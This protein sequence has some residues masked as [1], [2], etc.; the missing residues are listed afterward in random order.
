VLYSKRKHFSTL[1]D[2]PPDHFLKGNVKFAAINNVLEKMTENC[3]KFGTNGIMRFRYP[4]ENP[5]IF[6]YKP[7]IVAEI[8]ENHA[9]KLNDR[10]MLTI[11]L[12][13][14]T[15]FG[16]DIF[17]ANG[18]YW[19]EARKTFVQ[20]VM[21]SVVRS[22]PIIEK[23]LQ[24]AVHSMKLKSA[25][26]PVQSVRDV[27]TFQTFSVIAEISAGR[28]PLS[29]QLVR[30]FID[31]TDKLNAYINPMN[32]RNQSFM[33]KHFPIQDEFRRLLARRDEILQQWIDQHRET[34]DPEN[35]QDFLDSIIVD[36]ESGDAKIPLS[37]IHVLL[38]TFLGGTDTS[39]STIEFLIGYLANWTQMSKA[40]IQHWTMKRICLI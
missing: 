18:E 2:G 22:V 28:I 30:E 39:S 6:L 40:D 37:L 17:M 9:D 10:T 1:P 31:L 32:S 16:K 11:S 35:P 36:S 33:I 21:S 7:D 24:K 27:L 23:H 29:E 5:I 26:N 8:F 20:G 38:D 3:R 19:K 12:K 15:G 13:E 4:Y 34:L 14:F 25:E